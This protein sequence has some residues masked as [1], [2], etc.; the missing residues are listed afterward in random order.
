VIGTI[1]QAVTGQV[2]GEPLDPVLNASHALVIFGQLDPELPL[3]GREAG[4]RGD[5]GAGFKVSHSTSSVDR[6]GLC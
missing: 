6:S 3:T 1:V 2:G 5:N 4:E